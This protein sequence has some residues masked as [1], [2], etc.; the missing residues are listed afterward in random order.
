[1]EEGEIWDLIWITQPEG[2]IGL[3]NDLGGVE[4]WMRDSIRMSNDL[5][6]DWVIVVNVP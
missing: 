2:Q 6:L 1:M 3:A 5:Y 4:N